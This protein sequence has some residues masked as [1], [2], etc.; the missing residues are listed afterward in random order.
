M[1]IAFP[2]QNLCW[3]RA[4]ILRYTYIACIVDINLSYYACTYSE[5]KI[6]FSI[7]LLGIKKNV[8]IL[9]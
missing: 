9:F 3:E 7:L 6:L 4:Y 2:R 8:L 5:I 1:L